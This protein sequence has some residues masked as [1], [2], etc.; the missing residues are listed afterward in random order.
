[1]SC[2]ECS[3]FKSKVLRLLAYL[4]SFICMCEKCCYPKKVCQCKEVESGK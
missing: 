1:M 4:T 3:E 2:D